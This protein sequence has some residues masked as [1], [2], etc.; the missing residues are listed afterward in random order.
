M[1][2]L[3]QLTNTRPATE[4]DFRTPTGTLVLNLEYYERML[5]TKDWVRQITDEDTDREWLKTKIATGYIQVP[6]IPIYW[7]QKPLEELTESLK[8]A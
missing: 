6:V 2:K 4:A 8:T 7:D 5:Y 1:K 3:K